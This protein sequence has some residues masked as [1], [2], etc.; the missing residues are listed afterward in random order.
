MARRNLRQARPWLDE[1]AAEQLAYLPVPFSCFGR[2][3][4]VAVDV[5]TRFAPRRPA[6][7]PP[8]PHG[9]LLRRAW[10]RLGVE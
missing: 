7:W 6:P 3:R 8:Q 2:A 5:V 4:P 10:A 1:A 9:L